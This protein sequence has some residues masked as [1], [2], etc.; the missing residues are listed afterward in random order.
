MSFIACTLASRSSF[1]SRARK[2]RRARQLGPRTQLLVSLLRLLGRMP[3]LS[4]FFSHVSPRVAEA[5]VRAWC[6][7]E[8]GCIRK[9]QA[10]RGMPGHMRKPST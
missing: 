5:D 1:I 6:L 8:V 9:A 3:R 2:K 4:L 10:D 7:R